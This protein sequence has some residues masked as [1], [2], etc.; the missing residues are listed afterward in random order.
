MWVSY[1]FNS[2]H[3]YN[4]FCKGRNFRHVAFVGLM[5]L[6][7]MPVRI[8]CTTLWSRVFLSIVYCEGIFMYLCQLFCFVHSTNSENI[9]SFCYTR[10]VTSTGLHRCEFDF[11]RACVYCVCA[12][13]RTK[14]KKK[15]VESSVI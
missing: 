1:N 13:V 7:I 9:C 12:C 5:N 15:K 8:W 4:D 6:Q 2:W 10:K 11:V 14:R 3:K